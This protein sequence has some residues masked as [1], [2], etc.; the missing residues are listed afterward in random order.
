MRSLALR[1]DSGLLTDAAAG[2]A[3][4]SR[5]V[6]KAIALAVASGL[7]CAASFPPLDAWPLAWVVMQGW[8][9][10]FDDPIALSPLYFFGAGL[11]AALIA[12]VTVLGQSLRA[13]RATPAWALRHD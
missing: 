6:V 3:S 1:V 7:L 2:D 9:A 11:L 10:G 13:A 5:P 8:L 4:T 12:G